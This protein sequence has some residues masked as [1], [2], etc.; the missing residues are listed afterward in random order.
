MSAAA[1]HFLIVG[2]GNLPYPATRHS[3]GH[4]VVDS[5]AS[6]LGVSLGADRASG[7]F[8]ATKMGV[9]FGQT[10]ATITLYKPK[11]SMN[12]S[13]RPVADA[14]KIT[15]VSPSNMV[16]IHDSLSH[17]QLIVSAK[18]GGSANGHNGVRSIITAIGGNM[19]FHRLRIGIGRSD[20]DVAEYVLGRLSSF[21]RQFWSSNGEGL[22]LV[23]KELS[24]VVGQRGAGAR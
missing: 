20:G 12:I 8:K 16:V 7:G 17:E 9:L 5:L 19:G 11:A 1:P 18:S 21:E 14:L 6:R 15:A 13:G 2:L 3:V 10:S 4:L 22:D 23:W 24:K